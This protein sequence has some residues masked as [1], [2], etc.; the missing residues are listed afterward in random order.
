MFIPPSTYGSPHVSNV[1]NRGSTV[2]RWCGVGLVLDLHTKG[3][4]GAG[5]CCGFNSGL[6]AG[7]RIESDPQ[8]LPAPPRPLHPLPTPPH[9]H[10][11]SGAAPLWLGLDFLPSMEHMETSIPCLASQQRQDCCCVTGRDCS[12]TCC[13]PEREQSQQHLIVWW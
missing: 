13:A 6:E 2:N 8:Q 10:T 11:L 3:G 9:T 12:S 1:D 5:S 4:R 7:L